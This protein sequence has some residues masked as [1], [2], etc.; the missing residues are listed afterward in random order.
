MINNDKP[1]QLQKL[2]PIERYLY[3]HYRSDRYMRIMRPVSNDPLIAQLPRY[4]YPLSILLLDKERNLPYLLND[5][6]NI[7]GLTENGQ[8]YN[9]AYDWLYINHGAITYEC[10]VFPVEL[11]KEPKP[12]INFILGLL[13]NDRYCIIDMDE[14]YYKHSNNFCREHNVNGYLVR[15]IDTEIHKI[16]L[17]GVS[18]GNCH[19]TD[20]GFKEFVKAISISNGRFVVHCIKENFENLV[21]TFEEQRFLESI[22]IRKKTIYKE[23]VNEGE[24]F[25]FDALYNFA[26]QIKS[27][28]IVCP[29]WLVNSALSLR[30]HHTIMATRLMWLNQKGKIPETILFQHNSIC[31]LA[32]DIYALSLQYERICKDSSMNNKSN[33]TASSTGFP[34]KILEVILNKVFQMCDKEEQFIII[35]R[36][37]MGMK[38]EKNEY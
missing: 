36:N 27:Q 28:E 3:I 11:L 23:S 30:E 25:G 18:D 24:L 6:Y 10:G 4:A 1:E 31:A 5:F 9:A 17:F 2:S 37:V 33:C 26:N 19:E 8:L 14:Y 38:A 21:P 34:Q 13:A 22:Q 32:K 12:V 35:F 29:Q 20:I 16:Y 7:C 15:G